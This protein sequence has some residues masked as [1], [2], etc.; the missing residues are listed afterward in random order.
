MYN[1]QW[2]FGTIVLFDVVW[3]V[4]LVAFIL[5][6]KYGQ[7]APGTEEGEDPEKLEILGPDAGDVLADIKK[8]Q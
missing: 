4:I 2:S 8:I 6:G 5:M 7:A 1:Q 3:L